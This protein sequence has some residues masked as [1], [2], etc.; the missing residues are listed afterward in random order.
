MR[1]HVFLE[2]VF[3]DSVTYTEHAKRKTYSNGCGIRI[4]ETVARCTALPVKGILI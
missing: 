1:R 4:E 3:R 2:N